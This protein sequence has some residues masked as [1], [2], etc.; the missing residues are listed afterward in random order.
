AQGPRIFLAVVVDQARERSFFA[1]EPGEVFRR[2]RR[3]I[4][5]KRLPDQQR[6]FLPV[7]AQELR[8]RQIEEV[9]CCGGNFDHGWGPYHV[10]VGATQVAKCRKSLQPIA[11]CVAPTGPWFRSFSP[12][13]PPSPR[14]RQA[15]APAISP[16]H[17][18]ADPARRRIRASPLR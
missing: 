15:S 9:F 2:Q 1:G 5:G 14:I 6:F 7:I 12:A 17:R 3:V 10:L 11:T 16:W 8:D 18:Q 13:L 4:V